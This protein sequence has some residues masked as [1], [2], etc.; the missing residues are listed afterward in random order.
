MASLTYLCSPVRSGQSVIVFNAFHSLNGILSSDCLAISLSLLYLLPRVG[1]SSEDRNDR[2]KSK[3]WYLNL[4]GEI[5][6]CTRFNT[7]SAYMCKVNSILHHGRSLRSQIEV[8]W[9]V[10]LVNLS[11]LLYFVAFTIFSVNTSPF[12][13]VLPLTL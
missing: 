12:G 8:N 7:M 5:L 9:F 3:Y 4:F 10:F 1:K 13:D 2:C 6:V 11:I